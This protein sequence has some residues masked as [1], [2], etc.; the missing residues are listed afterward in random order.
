MGGSPPCSPSR[1]WEKLLVRSRAQR[2]AVSV[3]VEAVSWITP[4]K[5]VG[6]P[7]ICRSQSI[8]TSSS[9]VAA[10]EVCQLIPW[11]PS[12]AQTRSARTEARLALEGK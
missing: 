3:Q 10:G 5:V 12:P 9:S 1:F 6:S 7:T 4:V 11:A 2:S 8:T